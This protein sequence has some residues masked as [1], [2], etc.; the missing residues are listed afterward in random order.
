MKTKK[1]KLVAYVVSPVE[2]DWSIV[3]QTEYFDNGRW[4]IGMNLIT[5]LEDVMQRA[6]DEKVNVIPE[7]CLR[8]RLKK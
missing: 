6:W 8:E 4:V 2:K 1:E 5:S 7:S 3:N